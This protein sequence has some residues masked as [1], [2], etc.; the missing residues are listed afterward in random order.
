VV[1]VLIDERDS[2]AGIAE[3]FERA[4]SAETGAK[5]DHMRDVSHSFFRLSQKAMGGQPI[6]RKRPLFFLSHCFAKSRGLVGLHNALPRD[7]TGVRRVHPLKFDTR[8]LGRCPRRSYGGF[9][10]VNLIDQA[11]QRIIVD[12]GDGTQAIKLGAF[13]AQARQP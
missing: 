8:G 1:I 5:D 10:Q 9:D 7:H 12:A 6:L 3:F 11:P 4:D 2:H 13:R